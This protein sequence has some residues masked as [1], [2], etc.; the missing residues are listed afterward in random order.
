M[1]DRRGTGRDSRTFSAGL[2]A[3]DA[4]PIGPASQD[5]GLQKGRGALISEPPVRSRLFSGPM[6]VLCEDITE[7]P[8]SGTASVLTWGAAG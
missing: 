3:A 4:V 8:S 7:G 1:W 2:G 5:V 6:F